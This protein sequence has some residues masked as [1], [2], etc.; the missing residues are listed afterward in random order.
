MLSSVQKEVN[1]KFNS[2]NIP[3]FLVML[4][5]TNLSVVACSEVAY[6]VTIAVVTDVQ[7]TEYTHMSMHCF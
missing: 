4:R 1:Y 6:V 3:L 5:E 2:V 7:N